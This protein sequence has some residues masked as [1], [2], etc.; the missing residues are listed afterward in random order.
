LTTTTEGN[1][2]EEEDYGEEGV[3][4]VARAGI[5]EGD[6]DVFCDDFDYD[7]DEE[8]LIDYG[9]EGEDDK[10]LVFEDGCDN[11]NEKVGLSPELRPLKVFDLC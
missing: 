2:D 11:G 10:A 8:D 6:A 5:E 3:N 9:Y 7:D 4:E 1:E